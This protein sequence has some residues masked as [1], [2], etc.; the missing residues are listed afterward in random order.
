MTTY[1]RKHIETIERRI[2]DLET[3]LDNYRG[4]DP[5]PARRELAAMRWAVRILRR[6]Q[7]APW[8]SWPSS[9]ATEEKR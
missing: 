9:S 2:L 1:D 5:G 7:P 3:R 4:R 8:E 6:Q